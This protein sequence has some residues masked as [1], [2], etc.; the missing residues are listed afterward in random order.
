MPTE[1]P[2]TSIGVSIVLYRTPVRVI[3]KLVQDLLEQG[4]T[5]VYLVDNSPLSFPTFE[6]WTPP[7]GVK[8][9]RLGKNVGYGAGHNVAIRES[10]RVHDYHL[11]SNPDIH[12]R[13]NLLQGLKAVLDSRLDVGLVMPE[14]VG[15]DGVRHY[16]C[17]RAPSPLDYIPAAILPRSWYQR[18]R[19]YYEMRDRSYDHEFEVE[20]LSGCFMFFRSQILIETGGFDEGYFMYFEDFDLSRRSRMLARNLYYPAVR[21]VHEHQREHGRSWRL[22]WIFARSALRYFLR[23]GWLE[24]AVSREGTQTPRPYR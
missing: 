7:D 21:V 14:V 3:D 11:I 4:A 22:R 18:R 13:P 6:D 17:K 8:V 15:P 2:L 24:S 23:W 20:C 12:L 10:V 19:S 16:L 1:R 5:T 9:I